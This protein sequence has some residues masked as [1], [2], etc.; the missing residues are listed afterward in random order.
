V[1]H[2][3]EHGIVELDGTRDQEGVVRGLSGHL[4]CRFGEK[5]RRNGAVDGFIFD[6]V[7]EE[8]VSLGREGSVEVG[9]R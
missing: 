1:R 7:W 9:Q 6:V 8:G 5:G 4:G 3:L 2:G